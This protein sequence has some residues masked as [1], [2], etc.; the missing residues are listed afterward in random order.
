MKKYLASGSIVVM[1]LVVGALILIS[2]STTV[3]PSHIGIQEVTVGDD[4][5]TMKG[6]I[7]ESANY[8][9]G[10]NLEYIDD[11]LF[12]KIQGGMLPSSQ[13]GSIDISIK[14]NY[15]NLSEIQLQDNNSGNSKV[16]WPQ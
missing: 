1:I 3:H 15:S 10:Y 11:V 5:I 16:I 7:M 14:N 9:R 8:F 6:E 12:V 4:L 13:K 2:S